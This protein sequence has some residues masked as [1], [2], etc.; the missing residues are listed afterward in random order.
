MTVMTLLYTA[1]EAVFPE[2]GRT[3]V[4]WI[5]WM[6]YVFVA[7]WILPLLTSGLGLAGMLWHKPRD[8][9]DAGWV[10]VFVCWRVVSP[11]TNPEALFATVESIRVQMLR[12]PLF[13]YIIEVVT[14]LP[15][16]LPEMD[17]VSHLLVPEDYETPNKS[18]FEA[19][20]LNYAI[21]NSPLPDDAWIVHLDEE[22]HPTRSGVEGVAMMIREE[23][24]GGRHRKGS[25]RHRIGQG[26][27]LYNR[28]W[29]TH[30]FL[31]LADTM[32]TGDDM[33]RFYLQYRLGRTLFGMHGSYIV[34]RNS[35]AKAMGFDLGPRGSLTQDAFWALV[36]MSTGRRPRW[37]DGYMEKQSARSLADFIK[38]RRRWFVGLLLVARYAPVPLKYRLAVGSATLIWTLSP[39]GLVFTVSQV[40][41]GIDVQAV[42]RALA[43]T[44]YASFIILYFIGLGLNLDGHGVVNFFNRLRWYVLTALC[45]PLFA[46]IEGAGVVYGILR[47]DMSVRHVVKK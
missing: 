42:T 8:T 24:E 22:T 36:Q 9:S 37:C 17:D 12:S 25:D 15:V 26:C 35:V 6:F 31:T 10:N 1:Q 40:F 34:V 41:M 45:L 32:R 23:E 44:A 14:D 3:P 28:D 39:L 20:A 21:Q 7:L 38:Q 5:E 4:T 43:N 30:P 47:P 46:L 27:I 18:L 13:P 29:K 16:P 11:G 2:E 33:G 19:R